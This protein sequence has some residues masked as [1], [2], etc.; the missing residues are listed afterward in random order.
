VKIVEL[1]RTIIGRHPIVRI[2]T[3]D[4]GHGEM[5]FP[6]PTSSPRVLL[7]PDALIGEDPAD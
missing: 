6:G 3:D 7:F 2:V 4:H 1:R 5:E